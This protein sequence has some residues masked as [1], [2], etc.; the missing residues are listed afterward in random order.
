MEQK[1]VGEVEVV[2]GW[3]PGVSCPAGYIQTTDPSSGKSYTLGSYLGTVYVGLDADKVA[4]CRQAFPATE[5]TVVK[6]FCCF[7]GSCI[8]CPTP[9]EGP[10]P[11][12][13][14]CW[15]TS[16]SLSSCHAY[17]S[18]MDINPLI[19]HCYTAGYVY[20]CPSQ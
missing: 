15:T 18:A 17:F 3:I 8:T 1:L 4:C 11:K 5:Y 10:F 9:C 14:A 12:C 6:G 20:R 7:S 19:V 13:Y 16:L 2:C